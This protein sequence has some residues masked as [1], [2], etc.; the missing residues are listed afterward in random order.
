MIP[1]REWL[2][3]T[4]PR[5]AWPGALGLLIGLTFLPVLLGLRTLAF[6]DADRLYAPLRGPIEAALRHFRLPLWNPWEAAGVPL[7]AEGVHGVLHPFSLMAAW[8]APGHWDVLPLAGLLSA[9][10]GVFVLARGLGVSAPAAFGGAAAFA[11]SG[12]SVSMTGNLVF[13]LGLGTLPWL[14]AALRAA[15]A[16]RPHGV[17]LAALAV[18][19]LVFSG[20][21]QLLL[22]GIALGLALAW[23]A[24]GWAG[25]RRAGAG[26]GL[27]LLVGAVQWTATL[28]H[29]ELTYRGVALPTDEAREWALAPWRLI[30]WIVPGF[31]RGDL[32]FDAAPVYQALGHPGRFVLPFAESVFIGAPVLLCAAW[33]AARKPGRLWLAAAALLLWA[34][35]GP[36]LGA[37]QTLGRLPFWGQFRYAEKLMAPLT[38]CLSVLAA[39]GLDR[40]AEPAERCRARTAATGVLLVIMAATAWVWTPSCLNLLA[41]TG[42]APDAAQ[43]I[44]DALRTGLLPA[45]LGVAAFGLLASLTGRASGWAVPALA[46]LLALQAAAATPFARHLGDP[47][48]H[49]LMIEHALAAE[50]PGPRL[51]HPLVR[52]LP[53]TPGHDAQDQQAAI[54]LRM[55]VPAGNVAAR[56]DDIDL[57]SGFYPRRHENLYRSLGE[58]RWRAYRRFAVTHVVLQAPRDEQENRRQSELVANGQCVHRDADGGFSIWSVPH[59]PWAFFASGA[60]VTDHPAK[61][62]DRL[63]ELIRLNDDRHVVLEA[64][65]QPACA[66]GAVLSI[67]RDTE[68]LTITAE[69]TGEA[70]LVIND[71]Y[72]PGWEARI[73]GR[74]VPVWPADVLVRAVPWPAGRHVLEMRYRPPEVTWGLALTGIGLL[75]CLPLLVFRQPGPT[76]LRQS[77]PSSG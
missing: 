66:T 14:L 5:L 23:Q 16:G 58:G 17:L 51:A 55:A 54:N 6:R 69:S 40:L 3:R 35:L 60:D 76:P 31:F 7:F 19:A 53:P 59:R 18:A 22:I 57:Y 28:R 37:L 61:A 1:P 68:R 26:I 63:L 39:L 45:A 62:R 27:G 67:E 38:L 33:G 77:I 12:F 9:A 50:A 46:T 74:A 72:W 41:R 2:R 42:L 48:A 64:A 13:L 43:A 73:D 15:G 44:R 11:L 49:A 47:R 36:H 65:T 8:V 4:G 20:D 75:A 21:T 71:A 70:L 10:W 32:A 52:D 56:L 29:L 24:G 34:A 30:E 25:L